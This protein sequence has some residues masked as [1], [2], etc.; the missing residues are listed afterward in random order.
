M[1]AVV[2]L[3]G[4][5]IKVEEGDCI[6]VNA[7]SGEPGE[8]ITLGNVLLIGQDDETKVGMPKVEGASVEASI[9]DHGKAKKIRVFKMKRRKGFR[10]HNGHRQPFTELKIDKISASS[11]SRGDHG[12]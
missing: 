1:F 3:G 8:K 6:R 10:R 4:S 11:K 9:L 5:Q 12:A 7:I 2:D